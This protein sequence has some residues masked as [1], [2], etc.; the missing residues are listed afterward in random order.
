MTLDG[1][2]RI[3]FHSYVQSNVV[4][5]RSSSQTSSFPDFNQL[6]TELQL[7]IL[8]FC[9]AP[10]LY[11][12]MRTSMLRIE[13]AKLFWADP[14][15]YYLIEASWL[16]GGGHSGYT[17]YDLS[18]MACAQNVE[19]EY[20]PGSDDKIDPTRDND[21][22]ELDCKKAQD[23]WKTFQTRFPRAKRVVVNQNWESLS[24]RQHDDEPV[25]CCLRVLVEACPVEIDVLAF[26]LV[27]VGSGGCKRTAHPVANNWHRV[28]YQLADDG[29]WKK[30]T[31]SGFERK[32][33]LMPSKRIH[34][35]VGGFEGIK[36][37]SRRIDLQ[38]IGLGALAIEALDRYYFDKEDTEPFHCPASGCDVYFEK[39]GQWTQHAAEA[40]STI[41][42]ITE[43]QFDILPNALQCIFEERKNNLE[44]ERK[45]VGTKLRKICN[46]WNEEEGEKRR[47][48][49]RGWIYQLENDE[50][51]DTGTKGTESE[52]W[53]WFT[54]VMDPTWVGQ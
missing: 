41:D 7:R 23:F 10:T 21:V 19:I 35:P 15:T 43:S 50:A 28:L 33:I 34:G 9:S 6:P 47:E 18:F 30:V 25:A 3:P 39:A 22:L 44:Q 29:G 27:E 36:Y 42:M 11:Q 48:I 24:I 54:T 31:T 8:T 12:I 4:Q 46:D 20:G 26:V 51:W 14:N 2:E 16:F 45:A 53:K 40:H 17:C 5:P 52:L 37:E 49:E 1:E 32:T 13:A 38:Q